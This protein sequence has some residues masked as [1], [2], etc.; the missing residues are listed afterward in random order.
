MLQLAELLEKQAQAE[1]TGP[2][3]GES[4]EEKKKD[5]GD[6]D[7][8]YGEEGMYGSEGFG[9]YG[10]ED[11]GFGDIA[12]YGVDLTD[13]NLNPEELAQNT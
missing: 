1:E 10:L 6:E 3:K 5:Y 7:D 11:D 2:K 13:E 12:M 9:D 4:K 8:M